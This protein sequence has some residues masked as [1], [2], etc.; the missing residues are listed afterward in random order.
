ML[1][2]QKSWPKPVL[3]I[4][5]NT[6][7]RLCCSDAHRDKDVW[8]TTKPVRVAKH[9]KAVYYCGLAYSPGPPKSLK[10]HC[11]TIGG[12][13]VDNLMQFARNAA[14]AVDDYLLR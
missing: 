7:A 6:I 13:V 11:C 12:K 3:N 10:G 9:W 8:H 2:S 1:Q 5:D 4:L 14:S